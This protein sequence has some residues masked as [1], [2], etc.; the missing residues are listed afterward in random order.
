MNVY[1]SFRVMFFINKGMKN[2][3]PQTIMS[4]TTQKYNL[5]NII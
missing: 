2:H 1:A 5:E 4:R 3:L